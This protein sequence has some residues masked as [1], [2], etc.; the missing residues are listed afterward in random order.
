MLKTFILDKRTGWIVT[1]II[2]VIFPFII[3]LLSLFGGLFAAV[4][5]LI[6]LISFLLISTVLKLTIHDWI[7]EAHFKLIRLQEK[8]LREVDNKTN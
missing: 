3:N 4:L 7:E 2:L 5:S 8:S 1:Y 6:P